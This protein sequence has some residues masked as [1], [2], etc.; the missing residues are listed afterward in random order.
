MKSYNRDAMEEKIILSLGSYFND[1][2][3][4]EN[5]EKSAVEKASPVCYS[6]LMWVRAMYDYYFVNKKVK[7][8]KA[9]LEESNEKV[10]K[11]NAQLYEK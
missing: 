9:A 1:P 7:P 6:M 11:L 10:S 3:A 5:L 4:K 8:K 2:E